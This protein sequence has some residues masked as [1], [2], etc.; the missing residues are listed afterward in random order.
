M[1]LKINKDNIFLMNPKNG[2]FDDTNSDDSMANDFTIFTKVKINSALL[3]QTDSFIISRSGAHS[4]ISALKDEYEFA[5]Y[6]QYSYWFWDNS[7]SSP[8]LEV[9]QV[10]YKIEETDLDS[11]VELAMVHDSY[12]RQIVC[13]YG[14]NVVGELN[15]TNDELPAL[16]NDSPYWFGCGSMFTDGETQDGEFEYDL[17]FSVR[18]ALDN[19]EM[20]DII[21]NYKTEYCETIFED[22]LIFKKDWEMTKDFTFFCDFEKMNQYKIWNY[23]FNGNFPQLYVKNVTNY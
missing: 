2:Y 9:R 7:T 5:S 22:N 10:H 20:Q 3:K 13:Y 12:E 18:R 8:K 19:D 15:Y 14:G 23:A 16:Y 4:G 21:A 6:I 1:S 17:M 11:F